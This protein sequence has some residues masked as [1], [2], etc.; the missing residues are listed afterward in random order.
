MLIPVFWSIK[1]STIII[2]LADISI[3]NVL[4]DLDI[5]QPSLSTGRW[6]HLC[7]AT[8]YKTR[9]Y[10]CIL[11]LVTPSTRPDSRSWPPPHRAVR[12]AFFFKYREALQW[13]RPSWPRETAPPRQSFPWK[14]D[15]PTIFSL[16]ASA[17]GD[18][19]SL[20]LQCAVCSTSWWWMVARLR[21]TWLSPA[22]ENIAPT[23]SQC[24]RSPMWES[25]DKECSPGTAQSGIVWVGRERWG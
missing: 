1:I 14:L 22:M 10:F 5:S 13:I 23:T 12:G 17:P 7:G 18:C 24:C 2:I 3:S 9:R 16:A 19:R 20:G 21:L 15:K 6:L 8:C 25:R 11:S 4:L